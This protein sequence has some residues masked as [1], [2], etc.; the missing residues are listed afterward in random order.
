MI[1]TELK[2]GSRD[3]QQRV[4]VERTSPADANQCRRPG[5]PG[6][7]PLAELAG[8]DAASL[9]GQGST[10]QRLRDRQVEDVLLDHCSVQLPGDDARSARRLGECGDRG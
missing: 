2:K 8:E 3:W 4:Q 9:D 10:V 1:S 5:M 6:F 7:D